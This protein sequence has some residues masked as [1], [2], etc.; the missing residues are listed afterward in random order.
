VATE[1]LL[2]AAL[3]ALLA[4]GCGGGGDDTAKQAALAPAGAA[5]VD[6]EAS[7]PPPAPDASPA[8]APTAPSAAPPPPPTAPAPADSAPPAEGQPTGENRLSRESFSY[9]GGSRDPFTSL[10]DLSRVGPELPDLL[11]VAI[12]YNT[13]S[14]ASS[15]IVLREKVSSKRHNLR[16]GDRIGRIRVSSIRPKD[17]T[18]TIDDFGTQREE[19]LSLR[20]QEDTP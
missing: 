16:P 5:A 8:P 20:K 11:L 1:R 15:V 4:A 14:P 18:F 6:D 7:T 12:Y 19:T 2:A 10:L 9:T 3:L 17:V 13:R